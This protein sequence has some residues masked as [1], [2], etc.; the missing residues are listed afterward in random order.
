M[1]VARSGTRRAGALLALALGGGALAVLHG[2]PTGAEAQTPTPD[3]DGYVINGRIS[4][5]TIDVLPSTATYNFS[6]GTGC[7][8]AT[9][10]TPTST[11]VAGYV[12][13]PPDESGGCS[14]SGGGGF[15]LIGCA[16]GTIT[17]STWQLTEPSNDVATLNGT[18]VV[19]NGIAVIAAPSPAATPSPVSPNWGYRDGSTGSGAALL[20]FDPANV[21]SC[22][23]GNT[24][25]QMGVE[26]VIVGVY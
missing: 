16:D 19:I 13:L 21:A 14:A 26:A 8:T 20:V 3:V 23:Q 1:G 22:A 12:D 6:A 2:H 4:G 7:Q 25:T 9:V 10:P 24:I 17:A 18:G 11:T 5:F 15:F